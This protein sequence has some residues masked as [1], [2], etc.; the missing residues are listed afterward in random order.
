MTYQEFEKK[1]LGQVTDTDGFPP[2]AKYQCVDLIKQYMHDLVG[3]PFGSY[4]NAVD[5]WNGTSPVV[6]T[7][8]DRVP[9]QD[10]RQ[11]DIVVLSGLRGNIFG[12]IGLATQNWDGSDTFEMLEQNGSTGNGLGQDKDRIR[13]RRIPRGRIMG[14]LRAKDLPAPTGE[15]YVI[16]KDVPAY[17]TSLDARDRRNPRGTVRPRTYAVY[18]K[19]EGMVN[20]TTQ[21]GSPGSWINPGDNNQPEPK[22]VPKPAPEQRVYTVTTRDS[23]GLIA[24][25]QRIGVSDWKAVARRNGLAAPYVI[26]P[27]QRLII[28]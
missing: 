3:L 6:L 13:K 16:V 4:G 2:E 25:M 5:Y 19:A 11:G 1:W 28:P 26:R 7:K 15:S 22:P 23:D 24:A 17:Y 9:T 27:G 14:M 20:V 12:H 18:N 8:F 21:A 10:V